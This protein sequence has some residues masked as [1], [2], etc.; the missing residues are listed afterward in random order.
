MNK[1]VTAI[2][3]NAA[4]FYK[5][6]IEIESLCTYKIKFQFCGFQVAKSSSA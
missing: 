4:C 1:L 5:H 6:V 2:W 3:N